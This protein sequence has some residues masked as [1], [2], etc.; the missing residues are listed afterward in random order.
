M[1]Q[2]SLLLALCLPLLAAAA[3]RAPLELEARI[4]LGEVSGRIDHL[5]VD[6]ARQRLYV[7]E[8]GNDS[9]GVIDLKN[10]SVLRTIAGFKEPQGIG[11]EQ[12][13]DLIFVA[14][15]GDGAVTMLRGA[16]ASLWVFRP[17]EQCIACRAQ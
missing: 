2:I 10:R 6:V 16:A 11:Y 17:A 5:G 15:A 8:L 9:I 7:S 13:S 3:D 1:T 14:T 4:P 12:G